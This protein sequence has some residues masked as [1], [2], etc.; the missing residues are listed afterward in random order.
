MRLEPHELD[1]IR[2]MALTP[3]ERVNFALAALDRSAELFPDFDEVVPKLLKLGLVEFRAWTPKSG[4]VV[5]TDGETNEIGIV[6]LTTDGAE[7]AE[8]LAPWRP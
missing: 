3:T 1:V 5:F 7:L 8:T 4:D 6:R 2:C